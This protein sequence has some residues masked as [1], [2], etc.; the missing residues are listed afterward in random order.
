M[1]RFDKTMG[2]S[3]VISCEGA[4]CF[5]TRVF[6]RSF[7]GASFD[8]HDGPVLCC[9][10]VQ[11][12][13]YCQT[14]AAHEASGGKST[15]RVQLQLHARVLTKT[16]LHLHARVWTKTQGHGRKLVAIQTVAPAVPA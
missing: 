8:A 15:D 12:S 13:N 10:D 3:P 1:S 14:V 9:S 16:Q 7:N 6:D 4:R 5:S 2:G 11:R